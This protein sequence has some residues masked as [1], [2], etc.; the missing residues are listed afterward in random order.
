M[1]ETACPTCGKTFDDAGG[2]VCPHC[3]ASTLPPPESVGPSIERPLPH[4]DDRTRAVPPPS[5]QETLDGAHPGPSAG[6]DGE[7]EGRGERTFSRYRIMGELG[8]GGMGIVY[9]TYDPKLKRVVALKVLLAGDAASG[10]EVERFFREAESAASLHHPNIVPIHELD[11]HEGKHFFTMD[12]VEG[13]PLSKIVRDTR[14]G[15]EPQRAVEIVRDVAHA[16]HHANEAGVIH[17]DLKPANVLVTPDGRPMVTDFGLAKQ[18][19]GDSNLTQSGSALGT[20]SYMAPEQARGRVKEIDARTDVYALGAVLYELVTGLPPFVGATPFEIMEKVAYAD[21]IPPRVF[22][23]ACPRDVET[24]CMKCLE[25]ER[26][27][28]YASAEALADDCDRFLKDDPIAARP[29][30]V[31]YRVRKRLARHRAVSVVAALALATVVGLTAW[32]LASLRRSLRETERERDRAVEAEKEETEQ[33]KLAETRQREAEAAKAAET[34]QRKAA[35]RAIG[36]AEAARDREAFIFYN[37][38]GG[39]VMANRYAEAAARIDQEGDRYAATKYGDAIRKLRSLAGR[40]GRAS[41]AADGDAPYELAMVLDCTGSMGPVIST[42][43]ARITSMM[44]LVQE[45]RPRSRFAVIG[46]R[47]RDDSE[48]PSPVNSGLTSDREGLAEFCKKL[49]ASG[50]GVEA[51]TDGFRA[52]V[53]DLDW[54]AE[55]R[56]AIVIIGD[57]APPESNRDAVESMYQLAWD[58][59][60]R[61][62]AV[63]TLTTSRTA[64]LYYMNYVRNTDPE[65]AA[66][67]L[68]VYGTMERLKNTFRLPVFEEAARI[69]GGRAL[70]GS[71]TRDTIRAIRAVGLGDFSTK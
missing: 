49:E 36:E 44:A 67:I 19:K 26:G 60:S 14:T 46:F 38:V 42:I 20:P 47:T 68:A 6:T 65:R 41:D 25:K 51:V 30:S 24:I 34:K 59:R 35:E 15:I 62:I 23:R 45:K 54:S 8:R 5:A 32:Y 16:V 18:V 37:T 58:A 70:G 56:K 55:A 31:V 33:R 21:P 71:D 27:R 13:E 28:R 10:E 48:M 3:G 64:W 40:G 9:K 66:V 29:A 53:V 1:S 11:V 61:G 50:G 69:G 7:V 57:E 39:L 12:F 17:R 4:D 43:K 63:S 2:G 52:A 22:N